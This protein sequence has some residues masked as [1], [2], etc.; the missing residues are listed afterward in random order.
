MSSLKQKALF[1]GLFAVVA[2]VA[3]Q[4]NF[5][6][7]VGAPNQFF[8]L[9]QFLG[10]IAGGFLGP[11]LG[12]VSVLGSQ[13]LSAF[14]LGKSWDFISVLRLTPMLFAAY[15]FGRHGL[16]SFE[17]LSVAVPL[18]AMA[19]FMLHPVGGKVWFF[20][21][22]WLIPVIAG[23]FR[24][25]LFWRSLGA[26]FMAHAVG[27]AIWVWTVPMTP[28]QWVALIPIVAFERAV[29]TLGIMGSFVAMTTV[30]AR[31]DAWTNSK[32]SAVLSIDSRYVLS[33]NILKAL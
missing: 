28:E 2:L 8:T 6:A 31:L 33:R 23:F 14:L 15:Y 32:L 29:F 17:K 30:L 25:S 12:A 16:K 4:V 18:V 13:L 26:T 27:G 11:V 7:L 24:N 20:S 19:A 5:S 3:S 22:Y 21:L 10:P 1:A 9:F